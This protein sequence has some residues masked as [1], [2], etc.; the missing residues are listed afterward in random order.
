MKKLLIAL[1]VIVAV[2]GLGA[3]AM[4]KKGGSA[5]REVRAE[6]VARRDLVS[7]VTASGKIQP[8]RKVDI[9]ADISGRVIQLAVEEGQW[10]NRGDLL[11]RIDPSQF[12]SAVQ[13]AEAGV[14]QNR[15]RHAE[16]RAQQLKAQADQ[17]RAEQLAQGRDLV[18]AQEVDNAR[19][20]AQVAAATVQAAQYAVQQA[21]ATLSQARDNLRKTT[22][23]APM[24]G[25]V[26]RL[27][28]QEGETAIIGTMNNPGSLLLTVADPSAMEAKVKVDETDVPGITVG[29][30]A[31]LRIDAFP[32][33]VFTGRVTRIGNSAVQAAG[34]QSA[35][36]DQQSVD[37]EVVITLDH[38]PAELRPD[39][40]TTAEIVTD[41]RKS[42]LA[43]PIIALT[44]RDSAGKKF[45][46]SGDGQPD[47]AA[48]QPE[49]KRNASAEVQGVF[50]IRDGKA[51]WTPVN[52]GITGGEYFE[53][54]RGLRGGETIV[55]GSFQAVR[56]LEDGDAVRTPAPAPAAARAKGGKR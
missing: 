27:N 25:R 46:A 55:A 28:I 16:A 3:L 15:A 5:G 20:Q 19:T 8:K 32:E 14:A 31:A 36:G 11:L 37:Y 22:I 44:V 45:K 41:T 54:T 33:R 10:V 17:R 1:G 53:V 9:S 40:S 42:T 39:L 48:P 30:S 12:V 6:A 2:G 23:V 29:D 18:S 13:Q 26:T 38:P 49:A 43:V 34:Q 51:E 52:V 50:V 7:T 35:T 56:E 47:A 21:Q 24:S 4:A